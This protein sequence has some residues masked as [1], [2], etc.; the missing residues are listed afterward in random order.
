MSWS[1]SESIELPAWGTGIVLTLVLGCLPG[2]GQPG[3]LK[4]HPVVGRLLVNGQ[5]AADAMIVFHPLG[6]ADV[7]SPRPV[8]R[9]DPDGSYRLMTYTPGDGAGDNTPAT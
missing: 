3:R 1:R 4:V 9:T 7:Q 8:A 5:P 2:C 6:A